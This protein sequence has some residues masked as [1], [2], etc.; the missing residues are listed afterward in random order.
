MPP[1]AVAKLEK[2]L[3]DY[4]TDKFMEERI[5]V[6]KKTTNWLSS[7][8]EIIKATMKADEQEVER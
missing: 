2:Q 7:I 6:V 1:P 5:N 3:R 4:L 8:G